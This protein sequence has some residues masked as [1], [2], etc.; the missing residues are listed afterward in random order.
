MQA[1]N[2]LDRITDQ[3]KNGIIILG[4]FDGVHLGHQTLIS[5]G[6]AIAK[7]KSSPVIIVNFAPHPSQLLGKNSF[8]TIQTHS[9]K[10]LTLETFGI[11]AVITIAFTEQFSKTSA[12]DFIK[13]LI[14]SLRPQDIITG[15]NFNFGYKKQGDPELLKQNSKP[16]NYTYHC[17]QP[18]TLNQHPISSSY[19]KKMLS[20]GSVNIASKLLNR[21]YEITGKVEKGQQIASKQLE[22]ATANITLDKALTYPCN[23]VYLVTIKTKQRLYYG[24]ANIGTRPTAQDNTLT[25]EAHI[26]DFNQNIYNE[27]ITVTFLHFIRPERKF[28]NFLQLKQ[29]I[30]KDNTNA[31]FLFQN[32]YQ[33][34]LHLKEKICY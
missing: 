17:I 2:S 32:Y 23:G 12:I 8:F 29:Q 3:Y 25:L 18:V 34:T 14:K 1:L 5:K 13:L 21:P 22:L 16:Y 19:I 20:F 33:N 6:K 10:L 31:K 30:H 15:F 24:I 7:Q 4:N 28:A 11:D 26:W 27:H 9:D